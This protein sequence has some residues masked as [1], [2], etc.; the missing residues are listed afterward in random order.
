METAVNKVS[1]DLRGRQQA[2][3]ITEGRETIKTHFMQ[4]VAGSF[5]KKYSSHEPSSLR[6]P[7]SA[8]ENPV[9]SALPAAVMLRGATLSPP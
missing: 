2:F 6:R 7:P 4:Q 9:G 8:D 1:G 3:C 5:K